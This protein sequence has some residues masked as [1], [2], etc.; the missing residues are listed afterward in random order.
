MTFASDTFTDT[1]ATLLSAH[2]PSGGGSWSQ[3]AS[4]SATAAIDST[5]GR[6]QTN[7][8]GT[9]LN[10]AYLL[11]PTPP[12]ADYSV[13]ATIVRVS[14]GTG[15]PACE[16]IGRGANGTGSTLT[17]YLAGH[18]INAGTQRWRLRKLVNG[19]ATTLSST[20]TATLT[21]DQAYQVELRMA[22]TTV[23]LY[24]DGVL[25]ITA[26]DSDVTAAGLSGLRW[27][28]TDAY[29]VDTFSAVGPGQP[30]ALRRGGLTLTGARRFGRGW[31][32]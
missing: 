16:V 11:S 4:A 25:T 18:E 22:G 13:F 2:T 32:G 17:C 21:Q 7:S 15:N 8:A 3:H 5:G 6:A 19:S 10:A 28:S 29:R 12:S 30:T 26:T 14:T 31:G 1:A 23:S 24:V 9:S 20:V 27:F